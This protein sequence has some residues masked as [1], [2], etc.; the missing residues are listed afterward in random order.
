VPATDDSRHEALRIQIE[1]AYV[2]FTQAETLE[3]YQAVRDSVLT[4]AREAT[5]NEA[6]GLAF[7]AWILAAKCAFAASEK[8][9]PGNR[10][11]WLERA[12][13]DLLTA[14][15]LGGQGIAPDQLVEFALIVCNLFQQSEKTLWFDVPEAQVT[16]WLHSLARAVETFVPLDLEVESSVA[17]TSE[18][19]RLLA[20][21][22]YLF[23][24]RKAADARSD[25]AI[26]SAR[27]GGALQAWIAALYARYQR[28][29][30]QPSLT[31]TQLARAESLEDLEA[32]M[33]DLSQPQE[34]QHGLLADMRQRLR[35]LATTF[36]RRFRSRTGR[37]WVAQHLAEMQNEFLQD[38]FAVLQYAAP[39]LEA[40]ENT[41]ARL[42]LDYLSTPFREFP[43]REVEAQGIEMERQILRFAPGRPQDAKDALMREM[44]LTSQLPIGGLFGVEE[45]RE[46]LLKALEELYASQK[47]GFSSTMTV[48]PYQRVGAALEQDEAL[49]E[50][51]VISG[52][53][54]DSEQPVY[55]QTIY[56]LVLTNRGLE[57]RSMRVPEDPE[58]GIAGLRYSA[59]YRQPIE[60]TP[61]GRHAISLRLAIQEG[62][63]AKTRRY[64]QW[65]YEVLISPVMQLRLRPQD[66]SRW[67]IVPHGVLHSIPFSALHQESGRYL[68]EEVALTVSPSASVWYSL[69][70]RFASPV[71][72]F[73][74]FANPL[75]L[76]A[77]WPPLPQAEDEVEQICNSLKALICTSHVAEEA[78]EPVAREE[79]PGKS[80]VHFATHGDFPESDV[81]DLHQILLAPTAESD[82][83][84]H[85]EEL[86]KL[87]LD[88][89]RLVA[90]SICDGGLYRIGP[91]DEPYG[92]IP[93]L[94]TA[95]AENV[96]G[97]LW[98]IEDQAGRA[99]MIE[100]YK[101]L[102]GQGPAEAYRRACITFVGS[103]EPLRDWA[104]WVLVGS[105][106]P[107]DESKVL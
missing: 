21:L 30:D 50:Y 52:G 58:R 105:G 48:Y 71:S 34:D 33:Q 96:L 65:F 28:V 60:D 46:R 24:T 55:E 54:E 25:F 94:L 69:Q 14:S 27:R 67:I 32:W 56:I 36:R 9:A 92:L 66:F 100:F 40:V 63:E 95:G 31:R 51:C 7:G 29:K 44:L 102:L 19:A 103:Q 84:L 62:D 85:A 101:H 38:E 86:R 37:M 104:S 1:G 79:I 23:G 57:V 106:R 68:I 107:W 64:L 75:L 3:Q 45:R 49:I 89:T 8:A 59:D 41:K 72:S 16:Q 26:E 5:V 88:E 15:D 47:A 39:A 53:S 2:R 4:G 73:I 10:Q 98:S 76:D 90:L 11:Q 12:F 17:Q 97:T 99:F 6:T 74:G 80:I 61:L 42:L 78:T 35:D 13:Q 70:S 77:K 81:I 18:T 22:S 43:S 91:G 82:G 83:R 20:D 87:D 93:A